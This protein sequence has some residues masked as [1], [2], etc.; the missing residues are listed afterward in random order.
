MRG[1]KGRVWYLGGISLPLAAFS[2]FIPLSVN[3]SIFLVL[4][5]W[6]SALVSSIN[7]E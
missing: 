5:K 1:V 4:R 3:P 6:G 2:F 7:K